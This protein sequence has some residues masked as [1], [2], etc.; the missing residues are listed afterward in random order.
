MPSLTTAA[1]GMASAGPPAGLDDDLEEGRDARANPGARLLR[2]REQG[3][4]ALLGVRLEP[5]RD[6]RGDAV[7]HVETGVVGGTMRT[8]RLFGQAH[9]VGLQRH[10][11]EADLRRI[12]GRQDERRRLDERAVGHRQHLDDAGLGRDDVDPVDRADT[13]GRFD[14]R[15]STDC[16]QPLL[17]NAG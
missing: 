17:G 3:H 6:R 10:R 14:R 16:R 8:S 11:P 15:A 1:R 9:Q 7:A 4:R 5:D 12:D 13:Q 2:R